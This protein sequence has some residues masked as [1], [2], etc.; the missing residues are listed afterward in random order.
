MHAHHFAH[1]R[2][3]PGSFEPLPDTFWTKTFPLGGD[4]GPLDPGTNWRLIDPGKPC[5]TIDR[6]TP[7]MPEVARFDWVPPFNVQG[8]ATMLT[9][10]EAPDD[11]L[12]A[13]IRDQNI[14]VPKDFVR[15]SRHIALRNVHIHPFDARAREP[16]LWPLDLLELPSDILRE[17]E[18]VVSKPELGESVRIVLP[19]GLGAR[20]GLG[21]VRQTRVT[22]AELVRQLESMRLDPNNAWE[23][24]GDEASLFVDLR[25]G[26]RVTTAVIAAPARADAASRVS[27]LTRSGDEVTGGSELLMRPKH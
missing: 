7:V 20:A 5:R 15:A 26:Q 17:L 21:S 3:D 23:L 24:S 11:T 9:I 12:D 22:E 6:I 16:F 27:F 19:A 25:P 2:S 1:R 8:G 10:V 13:K 14:L 18:V 4:C